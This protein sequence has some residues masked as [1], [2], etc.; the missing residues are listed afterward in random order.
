MELHR[1]LQL[2]QHCNAQVYHA[3]FLLVWRST[4]EIKLKNLKNQTSLTLL[5][6][7]NISKTALKH[8]NNTLFY[9]G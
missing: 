2:M 8:F 6:R 7:L 3:K 1:M 5:A 9:L 4:Q